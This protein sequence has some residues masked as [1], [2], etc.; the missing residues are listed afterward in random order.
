MV[1]SAVK[2]VLPDAMYPSRQ[3]LDLLNLS[4]VKDFFAQNSVE[5]V[6][7]LAAKVG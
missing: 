1:G 6:I 2:K 7:H 5:A 4:Q 3:D